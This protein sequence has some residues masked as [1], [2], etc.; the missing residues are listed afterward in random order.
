MVLLKVPLAA[1]LVYRQREVAQVA[2]LTH[3]WGR[4]RGACAFLRKGQVVVGGL[5]GVWLHGR[6]VRL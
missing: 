1:A 3:G 5:L 6:L 2:D 4:L